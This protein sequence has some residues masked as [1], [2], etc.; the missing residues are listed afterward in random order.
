MQYCA[1]FIAMKANVI[2][3]AVMRETENAR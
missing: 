1:G 2:C 3:R